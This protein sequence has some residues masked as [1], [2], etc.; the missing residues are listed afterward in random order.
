MIK[1][2]FSIRALTH[3]HQHLASARAR[4]AE[5]SSSVALAENIIWRALTSEMKRKRNG[6]K[7]EEDDSRI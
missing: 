2:R 1:E 5:A 6:D 7:K 3:A 4:I